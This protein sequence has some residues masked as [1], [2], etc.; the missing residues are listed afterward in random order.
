MMAP[1]AHRADHWM[2]RMIAA[3]AICGI[4]LPVIGVPFRTIAPASAP[5]L[6]AALA[7]LICHGAGNEPAP[8]SG[9]GPADR[10]LP[11]VG[12]C[13]LCVL[14]VGAL[15]TPIVAVPSAT[16]ILGPRQ[17]W[18]AEITPAAAPP[19]RYRQPPP[20]APPPVA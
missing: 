11:S 18:S 2:R 3:I 19:W 15:P 9:D 16:A 12:K 17:T 1:L 10:S 7:F 20:R 8:A 14:P 6:E 5:D 4:L 13:Q